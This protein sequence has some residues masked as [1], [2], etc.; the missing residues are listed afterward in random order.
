MSRIR[1]EHIFI[2]DDNVIVKE[3]DFKYSE[4]LIFKMIKGSDFG[5]EL[6]VNYKK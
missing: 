2:N 5:I 1:T 6:I 3:F 4:L